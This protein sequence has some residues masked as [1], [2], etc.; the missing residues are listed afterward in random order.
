MNG[1]ITIINSV[2]PITVN[3]PNETPITVV[4]SQ[5][6]VN[7]VG[8]LTMSTYIPFSFPVTIDGQTVFGPL[9][10]SPTAILSVGIAGAL[11]NQASPTPDFTYNGLYITLQQGLPLISGTP[12]YVYGVLAA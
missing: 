12:I 2:N 11:Q 10:I 6:E 7:I 4:I 5:P 8:N 9:P 3:I 1:P